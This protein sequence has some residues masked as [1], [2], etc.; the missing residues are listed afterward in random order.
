MRLRV[1]LVNQRALPAWRQASAAAVPGAADAL[2]AFQRVALSV[3]EPFVYGIVPLDAN[4]PGA[5]YEQTIYPV[6]SRLLEPGRYVVLA[7]LEMEHAA[8]SPTPVATLNLSARAA[9]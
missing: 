8:T 6:V 5:Y 7:S 1:S 4:A 3:P 2:D 9:P